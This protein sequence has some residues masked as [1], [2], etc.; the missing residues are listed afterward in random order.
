MRGPSNPPESIRL[1]RQGQL[2]ACARDPEGPSGAAAC[3]RA[4]VRASPQEPGPHMNETRVR[5]VAV[6]APYLRE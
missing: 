2:D 6:E 4:H 3:G 1:V 5:C